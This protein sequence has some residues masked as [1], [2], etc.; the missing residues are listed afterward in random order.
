MIYEIFPVLV[1]YIEE[2]NL[3]YNYGNML[4]VFVDDCNEILD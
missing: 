2:L 1:R 4:L 3:T